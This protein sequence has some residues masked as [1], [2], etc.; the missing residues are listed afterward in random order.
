MFSKYGV[1][2]FSFLS[3]LISAVLTHHLAWVATVTPA[4]GITSRTYLDKHSAKWV[5]IYVFTG[6][7]CRSVVVSTNGAMGHQIDVS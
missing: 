1:Y 4:G 7:I 3:T 2:H 5:S 6:V